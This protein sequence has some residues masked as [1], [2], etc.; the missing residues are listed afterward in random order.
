M[1]NWIEWLIPLLILVGSFFFKGKEEGTPTR[2]GNPGRG[3][4][5]PEEEFRKLQEEIQRRLRMGRSEMPEPQPSPV[6]APRSS[7]PARE[8]MT[9]DYAIPPTAPGP[10]RME[11]MAREVDRLRVAADQAKKQAALVSVSMRQA[12][13]Q[14]KDL[15][16]G[17]HSPKTRSMSA[18]VRELRDPLAARKAFV[19]SEIFSAPAGMRPNAR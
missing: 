5:I 16:K 18:F 15:G 10:S 7:A 3:Q 2:G 17:H 11:L 12:A 6:S 9:G 19:S 13:L 8:R 1:D 14:R 4:P